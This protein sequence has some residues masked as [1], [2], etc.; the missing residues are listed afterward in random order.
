MTVECAECK[1]FMCRSGTR[2]GT[3]DNCPM[4]DDFPE[5]GDLYGKEADLAFLSTSALVESGGYCQWTR[6]KELG[7][8]SRRMGFK[9]LGVAH[10]PDMADLA[11]KVAEALEEVEIQGVLPSP[12]H[13]A[14]PAAQAAQFSER[15]TELNVLG[16]MCVAHEAMFLRATKVPTVSLIARDTRLFHNPVAGIYTS[17]SY[18][19]DV[20]FG[21]WPR[22]KR[23]EYRGWDLDTLAGFSC[24]GPDYPPDP[25]P[26]LAEA[27]GLAHALGAQRIGL[28]FC[29]GFKEEAKALSGLLKSN[30]FEVSSTCCKT[31]AVPKEE[32]GITDSQK[33]RPGRPEMICNPL[34]QGEL[35]NRDGVEFV[36]ILGQCVGHDSLTLGRLEAPAV[37]LVAKDRVLAHNTVAALNSI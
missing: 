4:G 3:P 10:C 27:I 1:S 16:G 32:A 9:K 2:E 28:S 20:L 11:Q 21:H 24:A 25:H 6:L 12:A 15:G 34:A 36:M 19:K 13:G 37:Y 31:G 30:G 5:F 29:V 22:R 7:E 18:L 23:P 35:L 8:F 17:R 33:I 26:R 14:D